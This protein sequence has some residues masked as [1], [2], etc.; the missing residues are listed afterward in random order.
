MAIT[1]NDL[2]I[3]D[4]ITAPQTTSVQIDTIGICWSEFESNV[5]YK[6]TGINPKE[7]HL[8][9]KQ[10][11]GIQ[12]NVPVDTQHFLLAIDSADLMVNSR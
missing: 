8:I 6:I 10:E 5:K 1:V 9:D 3:G 12:R 7:I 4:I 11:D 2:Q